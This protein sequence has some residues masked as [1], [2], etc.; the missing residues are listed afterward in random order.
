MNEDDLQDLDL[1][2]GKL[3]VSR[4]DDQNGT[5]RS[6]SAA[7]YDGSDTSTS[8]VED[9]DPSDKSSYGRS[10]LDSDSQD[11]EE[12]AFIR[13]TDATSSAIDDSILADDLL[14]LD[15]MP[16]HSVPRSET[17]K[18]LAGSQ[19][20]AFMKGGI[21]ARREEE[22]LRAEGNDAMSSRCSRHSSFSSRRNM[23]YNASFQNGPGKVKDL[24]QRHSNENLQSGS[25]K[26]F[27]KH[28]RTPS[29]SMA[30]V[31]PPK[32]TFEPLQFVKVEPNRSN[33]PAG[34]QLTGM[35]NEKKSKASFKPSGVL[36]LRFWRERY[37]IRIN[38]F[39]GLYL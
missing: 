20:S 14:H 13:T 8:G 30:T 35:L 1:E 37:Q 31:R 16:G 39:E 18:L 24:T 15:S 38:D 11:L 9:L 34:S 27:T 26:A 12:S 23:G 3:T 17:F 32:T 33:N 28:R 2:S 7:E 5:E 19:Q 4:T 21:S 10:L 29:D 22:R 6:R 25:V 36:L